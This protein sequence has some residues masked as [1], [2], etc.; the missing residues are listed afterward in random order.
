MMM[1]QYDVANITWPALTGPDYVPPYNVDTVKQ[2]I[3]N[4]KDQQ[5]KSLDPFMPRWTMSDQDL[6]DLVSYLKTLK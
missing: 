4:G 2:A 5:N 1:A 3:T 6:T